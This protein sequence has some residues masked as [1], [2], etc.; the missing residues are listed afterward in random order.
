MYGQDEQT[1]YGNASHTT[2]SGNIREKIPGFG[3][4]RQNSQ[5]YKASD[6][7]LRRGCL[8]FPYFGRGTSG[9]SDIENEDDQLKVF[10]ERLEKSQ[11]LQEEDRKCADSA[12]SSPAYLHARK[13]SLWQVEGFIT[14]PAQHSYQSPLHVAVL[15]GSAGEV[16]KTLQKHGLLVNEVEDSLTPLQLA[17]IGDNEAAV[18]LLLEG[19]A[20]PNRV[21]KDGWTSLHHAALQV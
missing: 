20:D 12:S 14:G 15:S 10:R 11:K 4:S 18:E 16:Q 9:R 1:D 17:V 7:K 8:C 6:T 5:N 2:P 21:D 19:G 3:K 13:N